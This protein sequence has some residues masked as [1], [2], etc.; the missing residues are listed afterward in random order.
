MVELKVTSLPNKDEKLV[1]TN[2]VYLN[3]EDC[4][5]FKTSIVEITLYDPTALKKYKLARDRDLP[6]TALKRI[7]VSF[8]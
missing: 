7:C 2:S 8:Q 1:I 4:K 6:F 5:S 3:P